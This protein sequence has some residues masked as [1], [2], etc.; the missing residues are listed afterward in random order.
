MIAIFLSNLFSVCREVGVLAKKLLLEKVY[1]PDLHLGNV[2]LDHSGS[3]FLIDF[4]KSCLISESQHKH[5]EQRLID[6]WSRS[7]RKHLSRT[8]ADSDLASRAIE[9]FCQGIRGKSHV[10][11]K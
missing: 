1:H 7:A 9:E 10:S 11:R 2:L 4:D 5:F 6:R 8:L 3:I